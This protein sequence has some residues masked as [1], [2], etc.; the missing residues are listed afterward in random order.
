MWNSIHALEGKLDGAW[1]GV[2][3]K[4]RRESGLQ[5]LVRTADLWVRFL[6]GAVRVRESFQGRMGIWPVGF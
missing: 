1:K 5:V 6:L 3:G 4:G 2:A